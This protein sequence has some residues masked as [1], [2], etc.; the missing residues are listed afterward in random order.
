M[1]NSNRLAGRALLP[2]PIVSGPCIGA[3][4][5]FPADIFP[6]TTIS[7]AQVVSGVPAGRAR[8]HRQWSL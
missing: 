1:L 7:K 4:A 6:A 5:A 2:V 8:R 3:F